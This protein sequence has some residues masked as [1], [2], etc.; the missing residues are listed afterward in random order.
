M[1]KRGSL[2]HQ[3]IMDMDGLQ[4]YGHSKHEAKKLEKARCEELG[5]T[6]N[7]SRVEGIFSRKTYDIYKDRCIKFGEWAKEQHGVKNLEDLKDNGLAK[8]YLEYRQQAGDSPYSLRLYGSA[9][10]KFFRGASTDFGFDY[11]VRTRENIT[12]SRLA[13][14]HDHEFSIENNKD[15]VL[16]GK[17]TGLRR[18]EL[19]LLMPQQ[20]QESGS[21]VIIEIDKK[22]YGPQSKGGRNRIVHVLGELQDHVLSMRDKA[23]TEGRRTVFEKILNRQ[24]E[25]S[26][27]REYAAARY[28][29]ISDGMKLSGI[30]IKC[31]YRT[32]DGTH[33]SFDR[34]ILRQVSNDLG[35]NR[36]D[37]VV[38]NYL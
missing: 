12:R 25:H 34:D 3:I 26:L 19:S 11:P 10:A 37:V 15:A 16:F 21:G 13:R 4:N 17:A 1:T 7:P 20:I 32:K 33:R 29:E 9:I 23:I 22:K 27:R 36:L 28:K 31:N 30:E 24:D 8:E 38:K 35:H 5:I 6:W 2:K 18:T 14:M